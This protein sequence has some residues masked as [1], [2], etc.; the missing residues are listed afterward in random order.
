MRTYK[1]AKIELLLQKNIHLINQLG[2]D[3]EK[4]YIELLYSEII[5]ELRIIL[6]M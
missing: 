3:D 6:E 2:V 5:K 4:D 1:I